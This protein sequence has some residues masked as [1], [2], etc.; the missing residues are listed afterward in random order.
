MVGRCRGGVKRRGKPGRTVGRDHERRVVSAAGFG[1]GFGMALRGFSINSVKTRVARSGLAGFLILL[2]AAAAG[3]AQRPVDKEGLYFGLSGGWARLGVNYAKGTEITEEPASKQTSQVDASSSGS[4]LRGFVGYRVPLSPRFFVAAEFET[5][6]FGRID[7]E[8]RLPGTGLGDRDVWPGEWS[9][10]SI[11]DAGVLVRLSLRPRGI[12]R[13]GPGATVSAFWGVS[14]TRLE[15]YTSFLNEE[16]FTSG[17]AQAE[18]GRNRLNAGIGL[19]AG[20]QRL[21]GDL[22]LV[23]SW[24]DFRGERGAGDSIGD[25]LLRDHF[26]ASQVGITL[27]VVWFPRAR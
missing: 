23:F 25:P 1:A 15:Y 4:A 6:M 12:E 9:F 19:E 16:R 20:G 2:A 7:V 11:R 13:L 3:A 24:M 17:A 5:G 14:R 26:A 21:R 8:G 18:G 22:R 10:A 27:G